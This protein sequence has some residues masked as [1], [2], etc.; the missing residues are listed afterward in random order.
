MTPG[1]GREPRA[2]PSGRALIWFGEAIRLWKRGP[3]AFSLMALVV[4][5]AIL[6]PTAIPVVGFVAANVVAP[7][8][9][10]GLL[11][12]SLAADRGEPVRFPQLFMVFAAPVPLQFA[13]VAAALVAAL[14]ESALA[15]WIAGV[16]LLAPGSDA[17]NLTASTQVIIFA[18]EVLVSLPFTFVPM[19]AL[20]DGERPRAAFAS[21]LRAFGR[22]PQAMLV[23]G[24]YMFVLVLAGVATM[25]I[26]L[27]L[28]LPWIAAAQYA[29]WK[30]IYGVTASGGG[31]PGEVA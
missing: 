9:A 20:F 3:A 22:N 2:V 28:G 14:V 31:T 18:T 21:S 7:L 13:V 26:G 17:V 23:L 10:C 4:I 16:N 25:G 12:G 1:A 5:V 15:W 11:F 27:V 6:L 29:A 19:A 30:D 8:L 24:A